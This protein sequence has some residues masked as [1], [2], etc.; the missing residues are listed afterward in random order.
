[1]SPPHLSTL[2]L[3]DALPISVPRFALSASGS[4]SATGMVLTVAVFSVSVAIVPSRVNLR[5]IRGLNSTNCR[6]TNSESASYCIDTQ[7]LRS[8]E[9]T[10]ELQSLAY[11]V[12]R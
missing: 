4:R 2:S 3:H 6:T 8:E 9:H 5:T 12:C 7:F 10:S 11:L 1:T